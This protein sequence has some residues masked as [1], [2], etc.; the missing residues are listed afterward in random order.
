FG[1]TGL[2]PTFGNPVNPRWPKLVPGGSSSGSAV[3]IVLDE[4]DVAYGTDTGGSVRLPAACC[5]IAGLETTWGPIP[6]RSVWPLAP[7]L[8]TV[9]PLARDAAGLVV[10]MQLLEPGFALDGVAP[11]ATIGR[12]AAPLDVAPE[13][14]RVVDD[15]LRVAGF[16]VHDV[17]LEGWEREN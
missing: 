8:D 3:A 12:L 16:A 6:T 11:A 15:A 9:G 14:Q 4:A 2:N 7:P 1:T 10:G 17:T 13:M 5:G